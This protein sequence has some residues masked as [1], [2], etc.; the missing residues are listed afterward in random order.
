MYIKCSAQGLSPTK[1]PNGDFMSPMR[2]A[3]PFF[4]STQQLYEVNMI[5]IIL[6]IGK[7]KHR[8]GKDLTS[9]LPTITE[10]EGR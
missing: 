7:L 1:N 8:E 9:L 10:L 3:H 2:W 4:Q 6:Y 5:I